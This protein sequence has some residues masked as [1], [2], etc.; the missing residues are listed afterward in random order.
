MDFEDGA[1]AGAGA[2]EAGAAGFTSDFVSTPGVVVAGASRCCNTA[3]VFDGD[4]K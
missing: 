2:E 4:E 3:L 1:P